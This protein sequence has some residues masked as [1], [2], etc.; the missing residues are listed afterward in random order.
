M[1]EI[2]SMFEGASIGV[3]ILSPRRGS[4]ASETRAAPVRHLELAHR[5]ADVVLDALP[6]QVQF[7]GEPDGGVVGRHAFQDAGASISV[8][9]L[10]R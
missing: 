5:S 7:Q 9:I 1:D 2:D 10:P 8:R 4:P 3:A 6:A